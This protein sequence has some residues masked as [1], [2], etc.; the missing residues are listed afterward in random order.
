MIWML[1]G[2]GVGLGVGEVQYERG[3]IDGDSEAWEAESMQAKNMGFGV[4]VIHQ[5]LTLR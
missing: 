3:T 4:V 1:P 2:L 5:M